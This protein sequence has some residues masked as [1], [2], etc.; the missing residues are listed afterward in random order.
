MDD[1][2][3][4]RPG[5]VDLWRHA[6]VTMESGRSAFSIQVTDAETAEALGELL[7]KPVEHPTRRQISLVKLDEH[8]HRKGTT[9]VDVLQ[10]V[11]GRKIGEPAGQL[12]WRS[13]WL[14][15]VRRHD[16]IPPDELPGLIAEAD[17]AL[18]R[19][20]NGQQVALADPRVR[21]IVLRAVA[22][23]YGR[24]FPQTPAAELWR[25]AGGTH[26]GG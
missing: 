13:Q 20:L 25:L 17:A 23:A 16:G 14:A 15:Q 6:L 8:L 22:L 1:A 9:L 12:A 10:A 4:N 11:H 7:H 24:P 5:L 3:Y 21:H 19:V 2:L 18:L 26:Q